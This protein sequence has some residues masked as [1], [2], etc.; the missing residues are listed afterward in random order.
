MTDGVLL[1][2]DQVGFSNNKDSSLVTPQSLARYIFHP[3]VQIKPLAKNQWELQLPNMKKINLITQFGDG[4][5]EEACYASE[6]GKIEK[7][8]CL[9][10]ELIGSGSLSS[11]V[12][13]QWG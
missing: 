9:I 4:H 6:F 13:I 8:Q 5:I 2:S 1:V 10:V 7:T 12:Q 3:S 11:Q